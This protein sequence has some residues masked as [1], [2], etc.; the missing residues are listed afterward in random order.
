MTVIFTDSFEKFTNQVDKW[1][2][3][4]PTLYGTPARTGNRALQSQGRRQVR[5]TE[6]HAT[7]ILHWAL[8]GSGNGNIASFFSDAGFTTHVTI[9]S[10]TDGSIKAYRGDTSGT[11]LG[12]SSPGVLNKVTST[13]QWVELKA[14]LH[15]SSGAV[16]VRVDENVVLSLTGIN[17]KNGGTKT[18]FDSFDVLR[19]TMD[20]LILCNG[21]GSVNNDFLGTRKVWGTYAK[22]N[23][24]HSAMTNSAGTSINNYTYVNDGFPTSDTS[25]YVDGINTGDKDTYAL[26]QISNPS[27]FT[28]DAPAGNSVAAVTVWALAEKSDAG[29]RSLDAVALLSGTE[30]DTAMLP[31]QQAN[32]GLLNGV[33]GWQYAVIEAKPGGGAWTVSDVDSSEFGIKAT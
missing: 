9:T 4:N 5:S 21:A 28:P 11:L 7:F 29:A 25:D 14:V 3:I 26:Y 33:F 12:Q 23:G 13:Y 10:E 2:L 6:E 22:A 19:G 31:G 15:G 32:A 30:S 24:T 17:T 16:I 8:Y 1:N 18:V 20:D 27:D